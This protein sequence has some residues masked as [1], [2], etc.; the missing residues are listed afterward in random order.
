VAQP[1][2]ADGRRPP[3]QQKKAADLAIRR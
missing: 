2:A 3:L 1:K